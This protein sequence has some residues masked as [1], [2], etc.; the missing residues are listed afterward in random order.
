MKPN[1]SGSSRIPDRPRVVLRAF[2]IVRQLMFDE[3]PHRMVSDRLLL[4]MATAGSWVFF[5]YVVPRGVTGTVPSTAACGSSS[6]RVA[7]DFRSRR[8]LCAIV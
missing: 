8:A 1:K 2:L 4:P 7:E 5:A 3:L 6:L